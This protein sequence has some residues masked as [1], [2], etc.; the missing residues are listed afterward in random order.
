M[1]HVIRPTPDPLEPTAIPVPGDLAAAA[2]AFFPDATTVET[3]EG[4]PFV[5]RVTTPGGQWCV[6]RWPAS[7]T[8]THVAFVHQ[9]M[10]TAREATGAVVPEIA[11]LLLPGDQ[12]ILTT[13]H[14]L[15]DARQWLPGRAASPP[16]HLESG[17][18][19]W[20][21]LPAVIPEVSLAAVA[22]TIAR[23]HLASRSLAKQPG[24][25]SAPLHGM[26][27]AVRHA[28]ASHREHLRP[29]APKTPLVQRWLA[30]GERV[31]P[32]AQATLAA[33]RGRDRVASVLHL[34]LWPANILITE[35]EDDPARQPALT[36][37]LGWEQTST[38]S[39]LL[40]VA[41]LIVRCQGWTVETAEASIATYHAVA[42]LTPEDRRLLPAIAALDLVATAGALLTVAFHPQPAD[43]PPLPVAVRNGAAQLVSSLEA[44]APTI[45]QG[46][47]PRKAVRRRPAGRRGGK[48]SRRV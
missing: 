22:E 46:D 17:N 24:A 48:P 16:V 44:I 37:L 7:T 9:V 18:E 25:P 33:A 4:R 45:A 23:L 15:Y 8:E 43:E 2:T 38:G 12:S 32:P 29:I 10:S 19:Q 27:S 30:S 36:G 35:D 41:Q 47:A 11:P 34:G 20:I 13:E 21:D 14:G 28:W 31:L 40:D 39:P 3:V 1:H 26:V 5:A 6:R 42:P